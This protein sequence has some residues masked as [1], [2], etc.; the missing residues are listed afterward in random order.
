MDIIK[1]QADESADRIYTGYSHISASKV[2]GQVRLAINDISNEA[3]KI[4][5][6]SIILER[7]NLEAV[8]HQP[9]CTKGEDCEIEKRL[10]TISY[11]LNQDLEELGVI[12]NE[13]TFTMHEKRAMEERIDQLLQHLASLKAGQ[14]VIYEELLK[15]LEELK[16]LFFLGRKNWKQLVIGKA[17]EMVV[18]GVI[19]ETISHT[20]VE[21][22][23]PAVSN[24]LI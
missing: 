10:A 14:Q 12:R 19:S 8:K 4:K 11:Y 7:N 2:I 5:Y 9:I 21:A 18:G 22:L 3:D 23:K 1:I 17:S 24:L 6:L 20:I 16:S 15:E 13:N